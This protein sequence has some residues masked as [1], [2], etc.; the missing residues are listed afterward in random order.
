MRRRCSPSTALFPGLHDGAADPCLPEHAGGSRRIGGA[1]E[2]GSLLRIGKENIDAGK[3]RAEIGKGLPVLSF[4]HVHA[5][6]AAAVL[7]EPEQFCD[8]RERQALRDEH[9][10][11]AA[12]LSGAFQ[13]R[14]NIRRLQRPETASRIRQEIPL[15][16]LVHEDD[17]DGSPESRD[18]GDAF[19]GDPQGAEL[20][21]D[22]GSGFV[23]P[24]PGDE[25][26][27]LSQAGE[28]RRFVQG[29]SAE[30]E[31]GLLNGSRTFR[32]NFR[33]HR[34]R[35]DVQHCGADQGDVG[36]VIAGRKRSVRR[37]A[38]AGC[39][40]CVCHNRFPLRPGSRSS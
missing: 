11:Q 2:K 4:C 12:D 16:G 3:Q 34:P 20:P 40:L 28:H 18:H 31:A 19:A 32:E 9:A 30:G 6:G 5:D 13:L 10:G 23:V 17:V 21:Q 26:D 8:F 25:A 1:G 7:Q 15:A 35:Q 33:G 39:C 27:F 38:G 22:G 29:V 24:D 14:Q 37:D 36:K